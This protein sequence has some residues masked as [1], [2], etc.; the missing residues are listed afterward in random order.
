MTT[1]NV[2]ERPRVR[3]SLRWKITLPFMLLALA[4]GLVAAYLV[5][6]FLT[7]SSQE[8]FLRQL[9]DSGQ[10]AADA[11]V[12]T[13][14]ELLSVER[15]VANTEGVVESLTQQDAESM[16]ERVLP[17]VVTSGVDL[18]TVL[19]TSGVSLLTVRQRPGG[20]R[21]Q[22]DTLRG[23][24]YFAQ[25]PA[26]AAL[27]Q[28]GGA[29]EK[30]AG[31]EPILLGPEGSTDVFF[32]GGPILDADNRVLGVVVV[33]DYL[34]HVVDDLADRARSN[35][36]AYDLSGQ[37]QASSL[38]VETPQA[39]AIPSDALAILAESDP[40]RSPVRRITVAGSSYGEIL[41]PL[42]ARG[43]Q[44]HLGALGVSLLETD[45]A[46][47]AAGPD[48]TAIV[49][50]SAL[51]VLLVVV[52][53][54]LISNSITRPLVRMADA[55]TAVATGD[56]N[57]RVP[58]GGGDEISVLAATFN[59]MVEGLQEGLVYHDL[60]GRAV[61]PEVR[62]ELRRSLAEGAR[63][64]SVQSARATVM[65]CGLRGATTTGRDRSPSKVMESLSE[66]FAAL[67]PLV[68]NHGGVV[69]R[70][71]GDLAVALF[72][73][74]PKPAPAPVGALQ[75]T[76]AACELVD[77]VAK[78]DLRREEARL[79]RFSLGVAVATGEVVAGGLGTRD[80]IQFTVIGGAV[81]TAFQIERIL[82][83]SSQEGVM[84]SGDTYQALGGAREHFR[85][86][87]FGEA[88]VK[89]QPSSLG[90]HEVT[91]RNR[92]LLEA[93]GADFFD[94]TTAPIA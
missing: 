66:Y 77:L 10:Q 63:A 72:G 27:L 55:S 87:R 82:R 59:R 16:R 90:L 29:D 28:G 20:A 61:T 4:L 33:G 19:D 40:S 26:V 56:L 76:H 24:G 69:Y 86:G 14:S 12:R 31:M 88:H 65:V 50:M 78:I 21:G 22:Y 46:A 64:A 23:E 8:R 9:A 71:E 75:A 73:L 68:A 52:I 32:V 80:R 3:F 79:P 41:T 7:S 85:F 37:L 49:L 74:L 48:T 58:E 18:V 60:L 57:T 17:L 43:G 34:D 94:D 67:V 83:E 13:E 42:L 62:A 38:D 11:L 1:D 45:V 6:S 89:G 15:L 2:A 92:K 54:L 5:S 47:N 30:R 51:A 35:V 25:W 81:D 84:I 91:G 44:D 53:G 93:G 36:S 39:V 70:F